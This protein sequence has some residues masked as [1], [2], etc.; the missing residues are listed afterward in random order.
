MADRALDE[1]SVKESG[2]ES[3]AV[4]HAGVRLRLRP[5]P[6]PDP[7]Y[8]QGLPD[9]GDPA[10]RGG[11]GGTAPAGP[12]PCAGRPPGSPCLSLPLALA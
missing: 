12:A 4:F 10:R 11:P 7:V 1:E 8:A 2:K 6:G 9:P 5:G 3:V